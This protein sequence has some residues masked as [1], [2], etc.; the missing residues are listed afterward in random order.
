MEMDI[1]CGY[2][3]MENIYPHFFIR[4]SVLLDKK[5]M[6]DEREVYNFMMIIRLL[7][8]SN[9]YGPSLWIMKL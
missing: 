6:N 7:L 4:I 8:L 5:Y 3:F 1:Y 2:D 9:S